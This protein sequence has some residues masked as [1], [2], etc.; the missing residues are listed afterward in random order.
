MNKTLVW[1]DVISANDFIYCPLESG[2][3]YSSVGQVH[4]EV[5]QRHK[6]FWCVRN[7]DAH[8]LWRLHELGRTM[9]ILTFNT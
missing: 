5:G 8:V 2:P 6:A 7:I 4:L 1:A 9:S 3:L